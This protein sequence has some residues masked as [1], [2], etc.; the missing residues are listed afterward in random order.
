[1]ADKLAFLNFINDGSD[2]AP[3]NPPEETTDSDS[4]AENAERQDFWDNEIPP[5][6]DAE[7]SPN[8][9]FNSS[10]E[11]PSQN[12]FPTPD[13]RGVRQGGRAPNR[14]G[15]KN[16]L[17]YGFRKNVERKVFKGSGAMDRDESGNYDPREEAAA[18]KRRQVKKKVAPKSGLAEVGPVEYDSEGEE[19]LP[20]VERGVPAEE[21]VADSR[22]GNGSIAAE[23]NVVDPKPAKGSKNKTKTAAGRKKGKGKG[24]AEE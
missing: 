8:S 13:D 6:N 15:L 22:P 1:M 19:I 10:P 16:A 5:G 18:A 21:T 20:S 23:E 24:K 2:P 11:L 12:G 14:D 7:G 9:S 3:K 4:D 17:R